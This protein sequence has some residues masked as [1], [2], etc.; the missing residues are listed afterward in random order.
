MKTILIFLPIYFL[1][2]S[3]VSIYFT[4]P[5][6]KGG[7]LLNEIPNELLG[8]WEEGKNSMGFYKNGITT[9][10]YVSDSLNNIVDTIYTKIPLGDS[11]RIYQAKNIFVLNYPN[12]VYNWE[13]I[14]FKPQ[15]NGDIYSYQMTDPNFFALDRN[16]KLLNAIYYV[17]HEEKILNTL[18][19]I[20][21]DRLEFRSAT[22]L[23]K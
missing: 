8:S 9:I 12:K 20:Y 4:E 19:P 5:Q 1:F 17:D 3:C 21:N 16:L 2:G 18:N 11:L 14:A 6:P 7:T 10:T 22:L 15:A 13:I 23:D